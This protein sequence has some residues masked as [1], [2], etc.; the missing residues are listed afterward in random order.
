MKDER[1]GSTSALYPIKLIDVE[2]SQPIA[3]VTGL[4]KYIA[5]KALVRHHGQPLATIQLPISNGKVSASQLQEAIVKDCSWPIIRQGLIQRLEHPIPAE[6]L[7]A[8]DL[9]S[10]VVPPN[11]DRQTLV[12][13]AVCTRNRAQDLRLC[14]D[15][16]NQLDYPH[17]D[18]VIIDNAPSD[19][20]TEALVTGEYPHMRYVCEPRPG[21][22]WARNRAIIEARGDIIAY[23]DDD[24]V[25]DSGWVSAI[26]RAF[27]D[28]PDVMAVTGLVYPYELETEPQVLFEI[29]GGFS[30]GFQRRWVKLEQRSRHRWGFYG[31][32]QYGTGA[33]MAYR[34]KLFDLIGP[35]DPALDVGTVTNGGGDLEMFF[36]V[37]KEGYTLIYEP[38]AIVRHRHR[39]EYAKLKD[40][41]ANNGIGLLSYMV[42]SFIHYPDE[43]LPL[44][45]IASWFFIHWSL[46]WRVL[47]SVMK[48]NS[49]PFEIYW[50]EFVGGWRGLSRYQKARRR[51]A[52]IEAS[53]SSQPI[54]EKQ[55]P[56][57]DE[58][59]GRRK[60]EERWAVRHVDLTTELPDFVDLPAYS[61]VRIIVTCGRVTLGSLDIQNNYSPISSS[62]LRSLLADQFG[63]QLF[64]I[65]EREG[66]QF[67]WLDLQNSLKKSIGLEPL[68]PA[69]A[70]YDPLPDDIPVSIIVATHDRPDDLRSNLEHIMAQETSRPVEVIVIDNNP[71]SGQTPP[72]VAEFPGVILIDEPRKGVAYARNAG[73][74]ACTGHIAITT[75]DDVEVP[76]FWLERL[77]APFN[78]QDVMVVTG[79][80][81][82]K[83]LENE[84]QRSFEKYGGLGRGFKRFEVGHDWFE[85]FKFNAVHTWV[86]GG[87]AN[88]AFRT[89]LFNHPEVGLADEALGPGMPSGV[90]ED[91][92]HFYKILKA[93]YTLVYEPSA[94]VWHKHRSSMKS[95]RKQLYNYSK[96]HVAYNMTTVLR[97][98]DPR[99]LLRVFYHLPRGRVM[100]LL[101]HGR[102]LLR[103]DLFRGQGHYPISLTLIEIWGNIL[104]F[105]GLWRSR[106][107]VSRQ[108]RS[109]SYNPIVQKV[110]RQ[111]FPSGDFAS[112]GSNTGIIQETETI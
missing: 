49:V 46:R 77:I 73:F 29:Q 60:K 13:V 45:R 57:S 105:W 84:A 69:D 55:K 100:Q 12:T 101:Y 5:L 41:I 70:T 33:N 89:T 9:L 93:G 75:D 104:G 42:R 24:V 91:T 23:T 81:F 66:R 83:E 21:L 25:V 56:L 72:I 103:G 17:L 15:S 20:S 19:S 96:G 59:Q 36:R 108:G 34:R 74:I 40:Q 67:V 31:T 82:P 107:R 39:R 58:S 52:E 1:E 76:P 95:L 68:K 10:G 38:A 94:F 110:E 3:E 63:L 14:L 99:G 78:R 48:A 43:R 85:S 50:S 80:I 65:E 54:F 87:T 98:R 26:A 47:A 8:A 37:L 64:D 51:T 112:N 18:I 6:G 28:S 4:E 79:N 109:S 11:H 97:D 22:D 32:G 111:K 71:S 16:L 53:Y 86:L 7:Q 90:G 27:D 35:F 106:R 102:D 44:M 61:H 30:R 92:Y 2:L 62:R 88:A